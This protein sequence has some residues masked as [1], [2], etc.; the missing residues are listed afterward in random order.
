MAEQIRRGSAM[1]PGPDADAGS[2][3]ISETQ[4]SGNPPQ[5]ESGGGGGGATRR[6]SS[7]LLPGA[8]GGGVGF[9]I[10]FDDSDY[11]DSD[12]DDG[13]SQGGAAPAATAGTPSHRPYVGGFAAAAYEAAKL[14][15]TQTQMKQPKPTP[16]D[17]KQ[18]KHQEKP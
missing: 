17:D 2:Q 6:S 4:S 11:E 15:H 14:H 1:F 10:D 13:P 8:L 5:S 3:Q 16:S 12:D 7:V 9:G 18:Q